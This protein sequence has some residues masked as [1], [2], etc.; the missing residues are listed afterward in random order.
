M[1]TNGVEYELLLPVLCSATEPSPRQ[2]PTL[3]FYN[4]AVTKCFAQL[5]HYL[6]QNAVCVTAEYLWVAPVSTLWA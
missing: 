6:A 5:S 3:L 4:S 1:Q 2:T